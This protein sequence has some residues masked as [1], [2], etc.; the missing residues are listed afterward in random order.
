MDF[1]FLYQKIYNAYYTVTRHVTDLLV[2]FEA[3]LLLIRSR[4]IFIYMRQ[5]EPL[6]VVYKL[7]PIARIQR[8]GNMP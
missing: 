7:R 1:Y 6:F 8:E 3:F 5:E 4:V 2:N